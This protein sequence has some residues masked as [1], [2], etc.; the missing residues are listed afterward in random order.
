MSGRYKLASFLI[1][2]TLALGASTMEAKASEMPLAGMDIIL[3]NYYET[4]DSPNITQ[5]LVAA[6]K[7]YDGIG[8]AKV[9][10]YVNIRNK[11]NTES[12]VVG[13]LY[14]NGAATILSSDNG[15]TKV[16][17]GNVTG[18]IK[19][20]Y[21]ITGDKVE[22]LAKSVGTRIATVNTTTLNVR[23]KANT[24]SEIV[25]LV[26]IGE[27]LNVVNESEDW[28]NVKFQNGKSGYVSSDYV[29][30]HTKFDEAESIEEEKARLNAERKSS[31]NISKSKNSSSSSKTS[32][33]TSNNTSLRQKIVNYALKFKGNPYVWGGTSLTRGTDCSG[34]TQSVYRD[35]GVK[36]P[37]NSRSQAQ[38][39]RE[40]SLNNLQLGDLIFYRKNGVVNH[41]AIYIGNGNVIS[42][43][44]RK[45]GIAINKYNYRTPYK[46]VTYLR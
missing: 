7:E 11:P 15:W 23:E 22:D 18:Y 19:S 16:K 5:F 25:T 9:R 38:G 27:K 45:A 36:I 37:R 28:I 2:G 32:S 20:N 30:L 17:S 8:I 10:N 31:N 3:S 46:A 14:N 33:S 6:K 13:K 1:A 4:E 41:V 29:K 26:P 40:V 42:A 43:K 44:S 34:F 35:F 12:N 24:Q 21:L 39:G